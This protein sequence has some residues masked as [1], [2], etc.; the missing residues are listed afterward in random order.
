[1]IKKGK[2]QTVTEDRN[3]VPTRPR[4]FI[5]LMKFELLV[6]GGTLNIFGLYA[7][8]MISQE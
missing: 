7:L 6:L 4:M 5:N 2:K 1:M 8:S 3:Y